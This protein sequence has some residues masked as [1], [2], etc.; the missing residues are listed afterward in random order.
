MKILYV[1]TKYKWGVFGVTRAYY[2]TLRR[3]GHDVQLNMVGNDTYTTAKTGNFDQIWVVYSSK[4]FTDQQAASLHKGGA[5][6]IGFNLTRL[7]AMP[8][9]H[10]YNIMYATANIKDTRFLPPAIYTPYHKHHGHDHRHVKVAF[11]GNVTGHPSS[12][13]RTNMLEGTGA[14]VFSR[15]AGKT[16]QEYINTLNSIQIG[17]EV[18]S[19]ESAPTVPHRIVEMA[20]CGILVV[21]PYR[22]DLAEMF[23]YGEEIVG[24]HTKTEMLE[25]IKRYSKDVTSRTQMVTR[26]VSRCLS[27]HTSTARVNKILQ[28]V[29]SLPERA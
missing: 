17:L 11:V 6:L 14:V 27:E 21:A 13:T 10:Q 18:D 19:T 9:V 26:A 3:L 25:K 23:T 5:T 20:A 15:R 8:F 29:A 28:D 7:N 24:Y 12:K 16:G 2:E 4:V 22:K 1:T